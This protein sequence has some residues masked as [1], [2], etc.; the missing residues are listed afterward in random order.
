MKMFKRTGRQVVIK[1]WYS[2]VF[3]YV[4][5]HYLRLKWETREVQSFMWKSRIILVFEWEKLGY[6]LLRI[7][8]TRR[9]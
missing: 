8:L 3:T 2:D 7:A 1:K 9:I 4:I 5:T 6:V